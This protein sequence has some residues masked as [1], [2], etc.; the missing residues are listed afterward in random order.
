MKLLNFIVIRL[1][2]FF[3]LGIFLGLKFSVS[4]HHLL[5]GLCIG[6]LVLIIS[7][8]AYLK[9]FKTNYVFS[10]LALLV[11][12]L[13]GML[14]STIKRPIHQQD[15][16]IHHVK[17]NEAHLVKAEVIET[18]KSSNYYYKCV[19]NVFE[20]DTL[21]SQGKVLLQIPKEDF[22]NELKVG[23]QLVFKTEL[24]PFEDPKNP[25]DFNY[26]EFMENRL[27]LYQAKPKQ[28][29]SLQTKNQNLEAKAALLRNQIQ[30]E[31]SKTGFNQNQLGLIQALLLG[32][33]KQIDKETY[34]NFSKAGVVH[35]LAVSGLH[36]G[37]VL[38]L[39]QWLFKPL[40][41]FKNGRV[42]RTII[43][44][45]LLWGFA[46]IAGFSPSVTRAVSMF[47]LFAIAIN[48]K[49]KTNTI[50][51]LCL[52]LF[53]I[54]IFKPNFIL[55][56]G[57][58][59]SY[60]AVFSIVMLQ[61]K[62]YSLY[63]PKFFIDKTIWSVFTVT[64]TAQLG[65]LPFSLYYFHQFPGLFVI[66]NLVII[67]FLSILLGGGILIILLALLHILPDFLVKVYSFML[68]QLLNFVDFIALQE[69]FI[70]KD[71][72]FNFNMFL[73][74]ILIIWCLL[75]YSRSKHYSTILG[76]FIG[77]ICLTWSYALA[78]KEQRNTAEFIIFNEMRKSVFGF[79]KGSHFTLF[80]ADSI[81]KPSELYSVNSYTSLK[82]IKTISIKPPQSF[83]HINQDETIL[84][85]DSTAI[86]PRKAKNAII[87]L[88]Y[89]PKLNLQRL[90][91]DIE[92]KLIIAD[93][94]NYTSFIKQWEKTCL[95]EN[96]AFHSTYQ[97]GAWRINV[98]QR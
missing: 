56:V 55:E 20:I 89:S 68:D 54:L 72:Y 58:Q 78:L 67:P 19:I 12:T 66:A 84:V 4:I 44:I 53:P 77:L 1:S 35:I 2:L 81:L 14:A 70:F 90:I 69:E 13:I 57:F 60:A 34:N 6:I 33:K 94:N 95:Q 71:I 28:L 83:Y 41:Y 32:Q 38:L 17:E 9:S 24:S 18:L 26:K 36:V 37:I 7:H 92:P 16:L 25:Q 64:L 62:L 88:T 47:S 43:I 15:H 65:V 22:K 85:I 86:Y 96:I 46:L 40:T 29:L 74:L 21:T 23:S 79:K 91:E 59:L 98:E 30:F 73:S 49:R 52:S 87:Y 39:L 31:L 93:A 63:I 45:I 5:I 76:F 8:F 97:D 3:L 80:A 61:P 10:I 11:F 82:N 48:M 27:I 50:N 75:F 51:I 42:F